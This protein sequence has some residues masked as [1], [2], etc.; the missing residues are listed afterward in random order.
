MFTGRAKKAKKKNKK[1][2]F[3]VVGINRSI[4]DQYSSLFSLA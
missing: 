3:F 4:T 1:K 2:T